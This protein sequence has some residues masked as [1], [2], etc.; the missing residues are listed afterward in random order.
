MWSN[1]G[2]SLL[3]LTSPNCSQICGNFP[4]WCGGRCTAPGSVGL[5]TT[6][7]RLRAASG[8][9]TLRDSGWLR[10][11]LVGLF[12]PNV[13]CRH[14][15]NLWFV[16]VFWTFRCQNSVVKKMAVGRRAPGIGGPLPWYDLGPPFRRSAIPKVRHN[17]TYLTLS[18]TLTITLTLLTL[19][20]KGNP[21]PTNLTNPNTRYLRNGGP[22]EWRTFG[23]A[24]RYP[25]YNRHNG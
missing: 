21:N 2:H 12:K 10:T 20:V 11:A 25:W 9:R 18:L 6:S 19:T 13:T 7:G 3:I 24:D 5:R 4:I 22:S 23:M 16:N 14:T 15:Q 8:I 17:G 1:A